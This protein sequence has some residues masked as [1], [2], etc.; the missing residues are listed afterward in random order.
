MA[1]SALLFLLDIVSSLGFSVVESS[2]VTDSLHNRLPPIGN[3]FCRPNCAYTSKLEE[4][5]ALLLRLSNLN[6]LELDDILL[7]WHKMHGNPLRAPVAPRSIGED[8]T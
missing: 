1:P 3:H 5:H 4:S 6:T 2:L 7:L 8:E